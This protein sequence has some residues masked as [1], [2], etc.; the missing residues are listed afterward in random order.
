MEG[1]LKVGDKDDVELGIWGVMN[2][3]VMNDKNGKEEL[4]NLLMGGLKGE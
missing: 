4:L 2:E 3:I 1:V